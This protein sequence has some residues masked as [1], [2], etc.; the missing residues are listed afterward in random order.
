MQIETRYAKSGDANV[1]Y[2]VIG[3]GP[4]DIVLVPCW[5]TNIA[6]NWRE[7][8]FAQFLERLASFARLIIFDKRGTGLSDPAPSSE[9][10]TLE[11][12]M[13]DL[14]AVLDAVDSKQAVLF[15]VAIG[16]RMSALYAA[17]YPERV[18]GLILMETAARGS[19]A[20]DYPWGHTPE[21]LQY[22][23]NQ[24]FESWGG[25]VWIEA[26]APSIQHEQPFRTWWAECL[27]SSAGPATAASIFRLTAESDIRTALPSIQAPT[28]V[29]HRSGDMVANVEEGRYLAGQI[30]GAR[31]VELPGDDH[32]AYVG[33][34]ESMFREIGRFLAA[35]LDTVPMRRALATVVSVNATGIAEFVRRV[36]ADQWASTRAS[37]RIAIE[38]ELG[39]YQAL[40]SMQQGQGLVAAFDGPTRAINFA[41]AVRETIRRQGLHVQI[42]LHAGTIEHAE[43]RVAGVAVEL[44][45]RIAMVAERDEMLTSSTLV[46]LVAGSCLCF[47]PVDDREVAGLPAGMRLFAVSDGG[48]TEV[49]QPSAPRTGIVV[50]AL[51]RRER[52]VAFNVA[53][54]MSNRAVGE[55]LSISISTVER[56]VANI[57]MKLG[58]RSRVQLSLWA[59]EQRLAV[60]N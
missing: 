55:S 19:W 46:G 44:A 8:R 2:Q 4:L 17:T 31:F 59:A 32:L 10:F 21:Q 39:R 38:A 33:D 24:I 16:G 5:L 15:G 58:Y 18:R 7:P 1:A 60:G 28:L 11:Q 27:R 25:P 36:G 37:A 57:L 30:P 20:P 41:C 29:L 56:H 53:Q 45:T 43:G 48:A 6:Y 52:E 23:Y 54:G 9:P 26:Y 42:G 12:R 49:E 35:E 3:Q 14:T 47:T 34:Q 51:S 22:W 40:A 13:D 50:A